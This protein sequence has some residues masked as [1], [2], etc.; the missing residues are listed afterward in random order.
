MTDKFH[1][2]MSRIRQ[3]L[4]LVLLALPATGLAQE[5]QD[6]DFDAMVAELNAKCPIEYED[7]WAI[8]SITNSGDTSTVA[9]IV[10]S[11]LKGGFLKV[12]T[13][14]N[15]NA[16]R[17]WLGQMASMFGVDWTKYKRQVV[18]TGRTLVIEFMFYENAP[19]AT[20]VF[21]PQYLKS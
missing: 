19:E 21:T 9:L 11:V 15:D 16:R 7:G 10:P 4:L 17:M 12:L 8:S 6:V 18:A 1:S 14:D 2:T 5:T 3:L 13:E 20:M